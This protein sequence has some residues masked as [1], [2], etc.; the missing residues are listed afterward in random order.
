MKIKP[1]RYIVWSTD[2]EIDLSHPWQRKWYI[3]QVLINGRAEDVAE[4]DWEEIRR[5][6]PELELPKEIKSFWEDYFATKK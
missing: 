2:K 3:K 1:K 5:L 4:L 6:L